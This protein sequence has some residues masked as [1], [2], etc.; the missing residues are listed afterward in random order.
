MEEGLNFKD[1]PFASLK[2][3]RIPFFPKTPHNS[4][5]HNSPKAYVLCLP[6]DPYQA[7]NISMTLFGIA[8]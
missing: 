8:Q 3:S 5:W 1:I 6:R 2:T 4:M 7:A